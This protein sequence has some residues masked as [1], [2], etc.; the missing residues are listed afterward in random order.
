MKRGDVVLAAAG[1]DYGKARPWVVI[2]SGLVRDHSSTTVCPITTYGEDH[3]FR[4]RI[5][6]TT[7]NGLRG[8]SQIMADKVHTL[9]RARIR[10]RIGSL[11]SETMR[12]LDTALR[13][14][15]GLA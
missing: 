14:W 7:Q 3:D 13:V 5:E 6:P 9:H 1:G 8:I 2:Q 15:L 10:A 11:D 12:S 4:I